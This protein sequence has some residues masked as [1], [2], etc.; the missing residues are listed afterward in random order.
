MES[1]NLSFTPTPPK[2]LATVYIVD[3]NP[4]ERSM[5]VDYFEKYPSLTLKEFPNGDECVKD[6]VMTGGAP[7]IILMD[8]FLDSEVAHS[9]D[10][11]EILVKLKEICPTASII[12][13]TSVENARIVELARRKGAYDYIVKGTEGYKKLDSIIEKE[14]QVSHS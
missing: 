6:L 4:V 2:K 14:F 9:K 13:H 8:Y 12:M 3:D 11:L 7:D 1:I 5:M 10:G